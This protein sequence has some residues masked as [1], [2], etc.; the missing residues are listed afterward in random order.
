MLART[1]QTTFSEPV[2]EGANSNPL[3]PSRATAFRRARNHSRAVRLLKFVLPVLA[4]VLALGFVGY[5]YIQT[6]QSIAVNTEGQVFTDGKLVM[7]NP[8]LDGF[9]KDSRPYSMTANRAVQ[10]FE[11]AGVIEL[12][13]IDAKLPVGADKWATVG[14]AH[15]IYNR[16]QN[17]LDII[18]PMTVTTSDGMVA[19]LTSAYIDIGAGGLKTG[20]PVDIQTDVARITADSM[21][22]LDNGK[23]LIFEKRVRMNIDPAKMR[24][25]Q[26]ANGGPD[27]GE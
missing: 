17:S 8:K 12:D 23:T 25:E 19:K 20:D 5:S 14:A 16:D 18:S 27:A 22:L 2:F 10:D 1:T 7:A 15:G 21:S 13:D 24:S 4:A 26:Q 11:K 3:P 9:T 6:P